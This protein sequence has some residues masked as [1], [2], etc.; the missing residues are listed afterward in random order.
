MDKIPKTYINLQEDSQD[1]RLRNTISL[2]DNALKLFESQR[3]LSV[4]SDCFD[5]IC[6]L[7]QH[8]KTYAKEADDLAEELLEDPLEENEEYTEADKTMQTKYN[9]V[10]QKQSSLIEE[11]DKVLSNS[12]TG[13]MDRP[14]TK[15]FLGEYN[16]HKK[17]REVLLSDRVR[18]EQ[19]D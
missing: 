17:I 12:V 2:K 19:D 8:S 14:I 1:N 10:I 16:T 9:D 5:K 11:G 18:L 13:V 3:K 7:Q 15:F 4:S 6:S